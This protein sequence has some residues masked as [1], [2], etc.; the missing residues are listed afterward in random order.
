DKEDVTVGESGALR[1]VPTNP[2]TA[3]WSVEDTGDWAAM[4]P[5]VGVTL[6]AVIIKEKLRFTDLIELSGDGSLQEVLKLPLGDYLN[7]KRALTEM[8]EQG[9][10]P[11]SY[12][13]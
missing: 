13:N 1:W 9:E 12:E 4:I 5:R 3:L 7:V 11:P 8:R 2:D 6:K 10:L